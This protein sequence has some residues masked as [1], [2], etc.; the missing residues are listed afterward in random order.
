MVTPA[1]PW[2]TPASAPVVAATLALAAASWLAAARLMAGMDMGI[3]TGP[4]S[5]GFFAEVWVLMMAAM[6]L[7]GAA[8]AIAGYAGTRGT[9]IAAAR[10]VLGYL[11]VWTLAG[12]AAFALDRPHG[13]LAAG[14]IVIAVGCYELTPVKR[15]F[16]RRCRA[17]VGGGLE[18]GLCC[19][20]STVG[21][22]AVL[23]ALDWMSL[24]LMAL[25]T[26]LASAQKLLPPKAAIDVPVALALIGLGLLIMIA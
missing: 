26:I 22:M 24:P 25:V 19:V 9:R 20:G 16:R 5:F 23:V 2:R 7:P 12:I 14:A 11:A 6:M 1:I 15:R 10:F 18:Y 8:P 13:S 17:E 3:A 4:G 21:L